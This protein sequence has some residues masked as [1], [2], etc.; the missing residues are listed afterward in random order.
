MAV[1]SQAVHDVFSNHVEKIDKEQAIR[2]LTQ[3][4]YNLRVV[5]EMAGRNPSYVIEKINK[6]L[7]YGE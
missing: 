7:H 2:F 1:L 3:D 4:N 5:C 6:R